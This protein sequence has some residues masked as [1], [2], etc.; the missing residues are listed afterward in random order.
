MISISNINFRDIYFEN[1]HLARI[2]GKHL[3]A[4]L[5]LFLLQLKV[6]A[7]YVPSTLGGG[8]HSYVEIILSPVTHATLAPM[9]TFIPL[10]NPG[11]LQIV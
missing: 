2:V 1:K 8:Q 4:A 5:H 3:F 11:I 6:S 10:M 7:R 9:Q